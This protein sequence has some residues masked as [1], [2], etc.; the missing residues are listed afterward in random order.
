MEIEINNLDRDKDKY[1]YK[2]A[3]NIAKE[4]IISLKIKKM[5]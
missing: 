1:K 5:I 3:S 2:E 4:A